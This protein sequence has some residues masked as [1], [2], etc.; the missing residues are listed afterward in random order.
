MTTAMDK[1]ES[2]H[3]IICD[4]CQYQT[5]NLW[6]T[7]EIT[8]PEI[9]SIHIVIHSKNNNLVTI[10]NKK[11]NKIIVLKHHHLYPSKLKLYTEK[12]WPGDKIKSIW[13]P[14]QYRK[15]INLKCNTPSFVCVH[16]CI[17][18]KLKHQLSRSLNTLIDS[19]TD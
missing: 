5:S 18:R 3:I 15:W 4:T 12:C 6:Q 14:R 2:Y 7:V 13:I 19:Q 16:I 10:R 8:A 17:H 11:N 9:I 1:C